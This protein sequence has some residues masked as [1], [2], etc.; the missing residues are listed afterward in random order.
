[1]KQRYRDILFKRT[2]PEINAEKIVED[3]IK[4]S[5]LTIVR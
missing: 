5:G 4:K 1:M 2:E 3:V